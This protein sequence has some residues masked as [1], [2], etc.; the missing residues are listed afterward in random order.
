MIAKKGNI[1]NKNRT[2]LEEVIPLNVPFTISIDPCNLCNF[3]CGFCAAQASDKELSFK[4]Q[5]MSMSLLKKIVDDLEKMGEKLKILRFAADGEPML[6]PDLAN[7]ILYAKEKAIAEY[8][9]IVTNG[10]RLNP[11]VN[12]Q[13]VNCGVDRIRISIEAID[14][15]G[16][17]NIAHYKMNYSMFVKNI[18]DLYNKSR[19]KCHIYIK[20][21]DAAVET[22][23]KQEQFYKIYGNICDQISID[24]VIPLWADFQEMKSKFDIKGEGLHGQKLQKVDVCPYP[25]YSCVIH[26]NGDVA[27]CCAD[28]ER[29]YIIGNVENE[30]FRNI[31]HS[32]KLKRLWI[33]HLE[34][35]RN[36]NELCARCLLPEYDCNDNIDKWASNILCRLK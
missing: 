15:E 6:N 27:V 11:E 31:W 21:V 7:M 35:R 9:E 28:W 34:G 29:K 12:E 18:E 19:G 4:K 8:I 23:E 36:E 10:S 32:D 33:Q 13:I 16:Y 25:F 2:K 30:D 3:R 22:K 24:N 26:S 1:V 20:I 17:W 14:A 5:M